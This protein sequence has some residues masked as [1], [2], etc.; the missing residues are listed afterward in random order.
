MRDCAAGAAGMIRA[1]PL[2]PALFVLLWSTGFIAAKYGLPYAPP[3]KFLLVRFALV[4]ALMTV[5]ALVTRARWP[6]G[7]R[8]IAHI[9]VAASLVHGLYLGGVFVSLAGGMPAGTSAM[10]V[11]LQPILTVFLARVWLGER[12]T[13]LQWSGLV[14]GLAG[15]YLV[16][17]H[18]IALGGDSTA[19]VAMSWRSSASASARCTRRSTAAACDLRSGAVIQFAACVALYAPIV[20]LSRAAADRVD[21]VVHVRARLVGDRAVGWGDQPAVLAVAARRR[22]RRRASLLPRAAGHRAD[23]VRA[24]RRAARCDGDRRHGVD[25]VRGGA[26]TAASRV[27]VRFAQR[28]RF[29]RRIGTLRPTASY[30]GTVDRVSF[31]QVSAERVSEP[32]PRPMIE[33]GSLPGPRHSRMSSIAAHMNTR[34]PCPRINEDLDHGGHAEQDQRGRRVNSPSDQNTGSRQLDGHR[35]VGGYFRRHASAPCI[36]R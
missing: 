3:L 12:I 10:L 7:G 6:G 22:R 27:G 29:L 4:T 21:A 19:L 5:V 9:A 14:L 33:R 20:A 36:P 16:V 23:G 24:V 35:H 15:V 1:N 26:G 32:A 25:R 34:W 17:R 13:P 18:K 28:L 11:G 8:Q 2:L 31:R 30:P